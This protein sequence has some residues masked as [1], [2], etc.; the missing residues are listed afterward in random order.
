LADEQTIIDAIDRYLNGRRLLQDKRVVVTA[1]A[2][3]EWID[4]VRFISNRSTGKMGYALARVAAREG[5]RV[6]LISGPVHLSPPA[7]VELIS[8][9]TAAQMQNALLSQ[10]SGCELLF[11]AA[12]VEDLVPCTVS[13][14]KIRKSDALTTIPVTPAPDLT[15]LFRE[16]NPHALMVGFSVEYTEGKKRSRQ[17]MQA[18][19]LDYIAWNNPAQPGVGFAG[20]TN[21]AT[22][23]ARD[24]SE[25][26]FPLRSKYRLAENLIETISGRTMP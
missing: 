22:L 16:A 3:R 9:E 8:V 11:M 12:A 17:K 4:A 6:T 1:G 19:G 5:A 18:K 10:A 26:D 20:D 13:P 25:W 7:G 15:R 24:G 2:T 21:A 14:A 23:L